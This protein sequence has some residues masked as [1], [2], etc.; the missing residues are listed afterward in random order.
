M[1][2]LCQFASVVQFEPHETS[3]RLLLTVRSLIRNERRPE[4]S[5]TN[6]A[7]RHSAVYEPASGVRSTVVHEAGL[8][9]LVVQ[10]K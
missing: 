8:V 6:G 1:T 2:P 7:P 3:V 9:Q 5:I 10:V 4:L